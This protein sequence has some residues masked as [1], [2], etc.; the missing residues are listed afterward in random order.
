MAKSRQAPAG[1][2]PADDDDDDTP[3]RRRAADD[4][5]DDADDGPQKPR[6]KRK[7]AAGPVRKVLYIVGGTALAIALAVLIYWIY[8]PVGTDPSMFCYFPAETTSITGYDCDEVS[9][10]LKMADVHAAVV[11]V[12]RRYGDERFSATGLTDKDVARYLSGQA[13]GN[14]EEE[15]DLPEQ[16]KRGGIT[17]I[18]FKETVDRAKFVGSFTGRYTQRDME[19]RDGKKYNQ[20][21][22]KVQVGAGAD[23]HEEEREDISFFF[24]DGRTLVYTTTRREC[25]ECLKRSP[26]KVVVKDVMKD[27][28]NEMDG[29]FFRANTGFIVL[30]GTNPA[31]SP[32]GLGIVDQDVR[33]QQTSGFVGITG[34]ANWFAS[35]GNHFL[36]GEL[37]MYS[38]VKTA[39]SVHSSLAASFEKA[40]KQIYQSEGGTASGLDDPFNP[41]PVAGQ[42]QGFGGNSGEDKKAILEALNEY[43]KNGA[44]R[45]RGKAV[46]V[47]GRIS[48][49]TPEQGVFEKFWKAVATKVIPQPPQQQG[50]GPLG[51]IAPPLR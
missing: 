47:Q 23:A 50:Q 39:R 25:E 32:F 14:P 40:Q 4:E 33:D 29:H 43:V 19:S 38:D 12:Y 34:S 6:K 15:K 45:I 37:K 41:K 16:E 49:G 44:V 22:R 20:L 51:P 46:I 7:S 11:G 31:G 27:L 21:M 2:R 1:R 28:A 35:N 8:S 9:K 48:H 5:D 17:V 18:R 42:P 10:N 30:P 24:P 26:G 3:R 13:S 36:Y